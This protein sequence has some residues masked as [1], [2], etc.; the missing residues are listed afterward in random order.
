MELKNIFDFSY[1]GSLIP[2]PAALLLVLISLA[3]L[4]R[5][6]ESRLFFPLFYLFFI[7]SSVFLFL[8][9]FFSA[10]VAVIM[11]AVLTAALLFVKRDE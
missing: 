8:L 10:A 4:Q 6:G 9:G 11:A 7:L 3:A 2:F 5:R 1:L